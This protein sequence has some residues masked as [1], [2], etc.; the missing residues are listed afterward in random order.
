[1]VQPA[2]DAEKLHLACANCGQRVRVARGR[3]GEGPRCPKCHEPLLAG[4]PAALDEAAFDRFVGF[5]DLPVLIDFWAPWCGPC[6]SFAPIITGIAVA[7][8]HTLLVGKVDT[9]AVP[10]LGARFHI[11]SIP[12]IVLFRRGT[13]VARESGAMPAAALTTWLA[14]HGVR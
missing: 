4:V 1:M 9:E 12:T 11:R 13:E 3:L 2:A 7:L 8:R 14:G 10:A 5:N 6:K